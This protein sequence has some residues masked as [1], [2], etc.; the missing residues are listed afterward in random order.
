MFELYEGDKI[1]ENPDVVLPFKQLEGDGDFRS[2]EVC[3]LRDQADIIITNPPFS[4]FREFLAWIV[5]AGKK[6]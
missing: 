2:P 6:F 3:A 4:L 5:E 1:P